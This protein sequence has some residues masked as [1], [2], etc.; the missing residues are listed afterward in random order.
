MGNCELCGRIYPLWKC[1]GS[2]SSIRLC[3]WP[4]TMAVSV[5]VRYTV[6]GVAHAR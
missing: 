2:S 1:H 3:L 6:R 5:L 4:L